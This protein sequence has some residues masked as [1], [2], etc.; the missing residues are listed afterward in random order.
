MRGE[1]QEAGKTYMTAGKQQQRSGGGGPPN[2][3]C[4]QERERSGCTRVIRRITGLYM[5]PWELP[6]CGCGDVWNGAHYLS[7]PH[8]W[9]GMKAQIIPMPLGTGFRRQPEWLSTLS[10]THTHKHACACGHIQ[11]SH[12]GSQ[13][14]Q[15]GHWMSKGQEKTPTRQS[16]LLFLK[17]A[18]PAP[19]WCPVLCSATVWV[20]APAGMQLWA[21]VLLP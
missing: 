8:Q 19:S 14:A 2:P 20:T 3:S 11:V 9:R 18:K 15:P 21:H 10:H 17:H 7:H 6:L 4:L 13:V 16:V 1:R 5:F 12:L